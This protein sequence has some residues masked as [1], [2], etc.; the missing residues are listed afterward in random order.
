MYSLVVDGTKE[1]KTRCN[2]LLRS[3]RLNNGAD[4]GD[5]NILGANVVG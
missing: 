4:D 3:V 5:I 1:L 2:L